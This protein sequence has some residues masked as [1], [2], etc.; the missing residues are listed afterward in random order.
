MEVTKRIYQKRDG[1]R[2]PVGQNKHG[3]RELRPAPYPWSVLGAATKRG[4]SCTCSSH[5]CTRSQGFGRGIVLLAY[6]HTAKD[7]N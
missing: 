3:Y 2:I 1:A 5:G 7:V 6:S 4:K